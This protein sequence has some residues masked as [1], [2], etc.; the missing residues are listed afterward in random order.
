[1]ITAEDALQRLRE[2]NA[3]FVSGDIEPGSQHYLVRREQLAAGQEPFAIVVGC[4]DSRVP[5]EIVFD[6]G[7][8]DLFVTRVAGNIVAPSQLGSLEYA[9]HVLGTRLIVVVGHSGCGAVQAT[10]DWFADDTALVEAMVRR[11]CVDP[12][13]GWEETCL[14]KYDEHFASLS[15]LY[16]AKGQQRLEMLRCWTQGKASGVRSQRTDGQ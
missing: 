2:G 12:V 9:V 14:A 5:V 8:G 3:R 6:Q 13:K 1:M 16:F 10:I 4:S 7:L 11:G 15:Q